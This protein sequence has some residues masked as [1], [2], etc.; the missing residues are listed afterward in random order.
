MGTTM[1]NVVLIKIIN[2]YEMIY[3]VMKEIITAFS[4]SLHDV[5]I[6]LTY[7]PLRRLGFALAKLIRIKT[8]VHLVLSERLFR[9]NNYKTDVKS[10]K[11][12]FIGKK[13]KSRRTASLFLNMLGS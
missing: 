13:C 9:V 1:K 5:L 12:F 3:I 8:K 11:G 2:Y 7:V 6:S 10:R 4:T